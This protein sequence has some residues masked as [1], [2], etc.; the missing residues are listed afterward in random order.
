[1]DEKLLLPARFDSAAA[2]SVTEAL[3]ARRGRPLTVDAGQVE[4]AGALGLQ[5]LIAASRDWA[6]EDIPFEVTQ[7]SAA[8]CEACRTLGVPL[9]G[10]GIVSGSEDTA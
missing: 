5:A 7:A 9:S 2:Q 1:M 4:F 10:I 6:A 8:L 3:M